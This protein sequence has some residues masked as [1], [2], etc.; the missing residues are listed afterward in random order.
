MLIRA[1]PSNLISIQDLSKEE[2]LHIL[3][4]AHLMKKEPSL[5]ILQGKILG[6][7]FF[8]PSTRT[9]L[10]FETAMLRL[11]GT[12][13][14][15]SDSINTS[16]AKGESLSDTIKMISLYSDII[17]IR[18]LHEGAAQVAAEATHKPVINA[19][20]G[21]NQH[22]SQT[23]LDLFSIRECQG[24]LNGLNI[25]LVGDLKYG[26]TI[27][28]LAQALTHFKA[29]LYL[30]SPPELE[31]PQDICN[32][33]REK[34]IKYS[35]HHS[36]DEFLPKIDILYMTRLQKE[37]F[38]VGLDIPKKNYALSMENLIKVKP[39]LKVLHPLPR[40]DEIDTAVDES[41]HGYYFEQAK[42]GIYT[43]QAL[44]ALLLGK[45]E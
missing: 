45:M 9:R 22:P 8:E 25:A 19:G 31:M 36:F 2:I 24:T 42:N 27:H 5:P 39:N 41:P 37:R 23:L 34:G 16:N 14:G 18:H 40:I 35:Y 17:V 11:G 15:F 13:I 33:L 21:S 26:R 12:T 30:M 7:C 4:C 29:R 43:R 38:T 1:R 28:S 3:D 10:S 32:E 20:D 6:S 44:L